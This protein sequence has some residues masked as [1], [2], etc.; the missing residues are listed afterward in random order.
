MSRSSGY[1]L[2]PPPR[3]S[4]PAFYSSSWSL[5]STRSLASPQASRAQTTDP[6]S[7]ERP[8]AQQITKH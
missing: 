4:V 2:R 6:R 5:Q 3:L 1:A 8:V 7:P